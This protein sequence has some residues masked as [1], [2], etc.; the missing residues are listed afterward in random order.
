MLKVF[1]NQTQQIYLINCQSYNRCNPKQDLYQHA[2]G[3][4]TQVLL[5]RHLHR[6]KVYYL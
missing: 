3:L 5:R 6:H 1:F 4:R 2:M